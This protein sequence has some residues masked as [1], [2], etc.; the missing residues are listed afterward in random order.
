MTALSATAVRDLAREAGLPDYLAEELADELAGDG[1]ADE[2]L[3][4]FA[5]GQVLDE[6]REG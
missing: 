6:I 5:V 1:F 4:I 2:A 3:V